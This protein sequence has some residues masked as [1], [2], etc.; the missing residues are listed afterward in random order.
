MWELWNTSKTITG[1]LLCSSRS[2]PSDCCWR[3]S[4]NS[5]SIDQ[6]EHH[7]L[8]GWPCPVQ[9]TI[10]GCSTTVPGT[11]TSGNTTSPCLVQPP[12]KVCPSNSQGVLTAD[13]LLAPLLLLIQHPILPKHSILYQLTKYTKW[14]YDTYVSTVGLTL[15]CPRSQPDLLMNYTDV[16]LL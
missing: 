5:S 3:W 7:L 4:A 15:S 13:A 14:K 10:M 16:N 8:S 11:T 12:I 1:W 2:R 9:A 6:V